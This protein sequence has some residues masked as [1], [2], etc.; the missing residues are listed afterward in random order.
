MGLYSRVYH[1]K[2]NT[3][4]TLS[5]YVKT[6]PGRTVPL[7]LQL[8]NTFT[9]PAGFPPQPAFA[10]G[11]LANDSWQRINVTGFALDYPTPDYQIYVFSNELAGGYLWIDGIQL[12]EGDLTAYQPS[13]TVAAGVVI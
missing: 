5:M 1:L 8:V 2:P 3:K 10:A 12:E 4:Y 9:P 11:I 7:L 13:S 6:S